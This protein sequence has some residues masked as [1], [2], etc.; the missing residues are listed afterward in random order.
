MTEISSIGRYQIIRELGRGGMATVY[1]A[2]D[3]VMGR[4]VAVKA[5][6]RAFLHDTQFRARFERE[7]KTIAALD[8]PNIVPVYDSGTDDG[9]PFLVLRYMAGGSLKERLE[10]GP[11]A[12]AEAV[13]ILQRI[14]AALDEAH[15]R[16][17]IHR[18]L[19]PANILF[20][21]RGDAF[22]S[23]FGIVK[24]AQATAAYT[25]SGV[26]GTPA[27]MSPEQ[28]YGD[29]QIDGRSDIYALGVLLY[30][31]LTGQMPYGGDTPAKQMMAHVI[32]P[33]PDILAARPD[34]PTSCQTIIEKAMAKEPD[35]RFDTASHLITALHQPQPLWPTAQ[36]AAI[37]AAAP[38]APK[39]TSRRG[40][41]VGGLAALLLLLAVWLL[42]PDQEAPA[43]T[44][45]LPA[46]EIAARLQIPPTNTATPRPSPTPTIPT[47]TLDAAITTAGLEGDTATPR[48]TRTATATPTSTLTPT[49][50]A[51]P[52]KGPETMLLGQSAG[53]LDIPMTRFGNGPNVVLFVGGI[54]AGF[55][56]SSVTTMEEAVAYF[57]ENPTAVPDSVTLYIIP[58]LN[59]DSANAPGELNGRLN[60]N[61][62]DL[63]RNWD[64]RWRADTIWRG[65]R[66]TGLGGAAPFSEPE[67]GSL[68]DFILAQ[69]PTAVIIWQAR[70]NNGLVSPGT[71]GLRP[72]ASEPLARTF[73]LASGYN[74]ADF[75]DLVS[76]EVNGDSTNWI[77]WQGIPS[78][79][80]LLPDYNVIDWENNLSGMLAVLQT[81]T[82]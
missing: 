79:T 14:A 48:P 28:V 82:N 29:R 47:A 34:L 61:G 69:R 27:Y 36:T 53:G 19:K 40:W 20:D 68:A 72:I 7:V 16:G 6:P 78:I 59:P 18:D 26:I 31:M 35:G 55:A 33:V 38:L 23:D 10:Q 73:S 1:L 11:L 54:N 41:L 74:V 25:G 80:V 45:N 8:H 49:P 44:P 62:V 77:D 64:C 60:A 76:Q 24:L 4:E 70:I 67:T 12:Y 57:Q 13:T 81:S 39:T 3:P 15:G 9:Q 65:E 58:K 30:Q 22:L 56:P 51:T 50:S 37:D 63:N 42:R 43:P 2:H 46:T 75:E 52:G 5:L 21:Q 17:I 66:V 71:C 32:E